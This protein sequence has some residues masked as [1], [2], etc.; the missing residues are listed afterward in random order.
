MTEVLP[1]ADITLPGIEAAGPGNGVCVGRPVPGVRIALAPAGRRGPGD[2][3]ADRR[4]RR[5]RRDPRGR[6]PPQAALRPAL[7]D[8]AR[9]AA[10]TPATTGPATSGTSTPRA[11]CGSRGGWCTSCRPRRAR[12]RR[13]AWS[14]ASRPCPR[15]SPP[16]SSGSDPPAP[17]RWSS[18]SSPPAGAVR[19]ARS[20]TPTSTAAV[21]RVAGVDVAAV[22]AVPALPTDIRHNSKIDR[23]AV[24]AWASRVLAG[25]RPGSSREGPRH[26]G[27][28]DAGRRRR[29]GARRARRRGDRDA[30]TFRPGWGSA[31]CSATSPTRAAVRGRS[32]ARTAS[33]TSRP[34]STSPGPRPD[35]VRANVRRHPE[36]PRRLHRARRPAAGPGLLA[37]GQPHRFLAGRGTRRTGRPGAR[38]RPV[39]PDQGAVRARGA[40]RGP[41][42]ARFRW[43][44]SPSGPHIVWGPGDT[45]L[46]ER[47]VERGRAGRLPLLGTGAALIDTTYVDNAAD[48]LVAA[49]DR[50]PE[51]HGEAFVVSNGEPRPVGEIFGDFCAAAGVPASD[52]PRP[53]PSRRRRRRG[54]RARC[55]PCA[56]PTAPPSR[57]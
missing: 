35:Y 3:R 44:W 19:G 24:S 57:R 23:A 18:S 20:P 39:R 9:P 51:V 29:P 21:R 52:A 28:R 45:Q 5:D 22:L 10:A 13:S 55:G 53:R 27:Q 11:G 48:A 4:G 47:I 32:P 1:V 15:S 8:R 25:V 42:R 12:S 56:T 14:S 33:S 46:V 50:A 36:R 30:A 2:G 7:G 40:R 54:R 49:L 26:R 41:D 43:P 37:V 34:R 16:P 17:S 38:P 6:R 31:R